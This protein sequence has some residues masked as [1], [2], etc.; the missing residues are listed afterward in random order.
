MKMNPR[1]DP[2]IPLILRRVSLSVPFPRLL[3]NLGTMPNRDD[4]HGVLHNLVEESTGLDVHLAVR[5]VGEIGHER[6][7]VGES[8]Q[9]LERLLVSHSALPGGLRAQATDR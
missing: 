9:P 2:M 4:P 3:R 5:R 6:D 8:R 1:A 7:G